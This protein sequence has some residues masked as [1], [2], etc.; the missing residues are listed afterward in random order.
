MLG[1]CTRACGSGGVDVLTYALLNPGSSVSF[2]ESRLID[3]LGLC[4]DR[5]EVVFCVETLTAKKPE[6]LKS[7]SFS[8]QVKFLDGANAF[9]LANVIRIDQ[10]PVCLDRRNFCNDIDELEHLEGVTLPRI[11]KATVT[12]LIGNDNYLAQLPLQTRL[13]SNPESS[14]HAVRTP[15]DWVLKG[16]SLAAG[17]SSG[18]NSVSCLPSQGR[19]PECIEALRASIVTDEGDVY[20]SS[21]GIGVADVE[22][23]MTWLRSNVQV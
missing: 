5:N 16:P 14:P 19:V 13:A 23:L 3:K 7:E 10:I 12:L 21:C 4:G 20:C 18:D 8:L 22:N 17:Q 6:Q 15:L 1:Y 11:D 2:C 9:C